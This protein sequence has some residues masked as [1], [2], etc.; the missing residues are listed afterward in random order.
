VWQPQAGLASA[1]NRGAREARMPLIVF[2]DDDIHPH[3]GYA[4]A[5][6]AWPGEQ[7]DLDDLVERAVSAVSPTAAVAAVWGRRDRETS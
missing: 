1:R 4:A 2:S 6:M 5:H 7:W 3:P